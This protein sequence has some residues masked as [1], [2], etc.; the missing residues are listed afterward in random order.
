MSKRIRLTIT[1]DELAQLTAVLDHC[2]AEMDRIH[3]QTAKDQK[4]IE[5]SKA[6]TQATLDELQRSL[7]SWKPPGMTFEQQRLEARERHEREMAALR[8]EK[9]RLRAECGLLPVE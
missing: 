5:L 6:R 1:E 7:D 9:A 8:L 3:E 4:E 2:L